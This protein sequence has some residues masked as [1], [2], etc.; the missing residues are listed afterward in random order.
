MYEVREGKTCT[1]VNKI[2]QEAPILDVCFGKDDN[3]LY[4]AALDH[5]VRR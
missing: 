5:V 2:E 3:T 4:T 1:L